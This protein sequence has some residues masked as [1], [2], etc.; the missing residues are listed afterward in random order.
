MEDGKAYEGRKMSESVSQSNKEENKEEYPL[1]RKV[2]L[3]YDT[4]DELDDGVGSICS[5]N[6]INDLRS[7]IREG[8]KN[9]QRWGYLK[10]AAEP[11]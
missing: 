7:S 4:T 6:T 9:I 3:T 8:V 5:K 2:N 11:P 1:Y 10:I